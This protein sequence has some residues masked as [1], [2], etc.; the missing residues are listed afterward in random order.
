MILKGYPR[1][2][3]TF[4]SNEIHLLEKLGFDQIVVSLKA[5]DVERTVESNRLF[6]ARFD[7]PLHLGV[8]EA[9]TPWAGTI[10]SAVGIGTLLSQGIGETIRVSLTGPVTEEVRVG[11]EILKAVGLRQRGPTL[12]SC[13]TCGRTVPR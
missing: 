2:S 13:P 11:W 12:I 1:I 9:G 10:K 6:R 5:S 4:I 7:Y 3:E 8:T